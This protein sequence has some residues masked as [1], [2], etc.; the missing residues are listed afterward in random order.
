MI[1]LEKQHHIRDDGS[2]TGGSEGK[3]SAATI[4]ISYQ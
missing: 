2:R 3:G 4:A 1:A